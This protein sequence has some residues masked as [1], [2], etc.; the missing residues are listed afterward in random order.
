MRLT[1]AKRL[2]RLREIAD[3]SDVPDV[4]RWSYL[5]HCWGHDLAVD[6][7]K[8]EWNR[9]RSRIYVDR[10]LAAFDGRPPPLREVLDR[11]VERIYRQPCI[12]PRCGK[13]WPGLLRLFEGTN[14]NVRKRQERLDA[15]VTGC[16][17]T[18]EPQRKP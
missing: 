13:K 3:L 4:T 9:E 7:D 17:D 5:V 1:D 11:E 8:N 2:E 18:C 16:P 15:W 10:L 14:N 6:D 12:C